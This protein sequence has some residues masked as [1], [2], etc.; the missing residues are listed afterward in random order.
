[1][2][3]RAL[4]VRPAACVGCG[5]CE[6]T[7]SLHASGEISPRRARLVL[8]DA[9]ADGGAVPVV[10]GQCVGAPCVTACP[11][12]AIYRNKRT[13]ALVVDRWGCNGCARCVGACPWGLVQVTEVAE[14]CDL[15]GGEPVCLQ[16]CPTG[17]LDLR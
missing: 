1:M 5:L 10:C 17:A 13:G 7:C 11:Q 4:M 12:Q 14:K 6:L 9:G 8:V 3:T 15:C 16:V 2:T